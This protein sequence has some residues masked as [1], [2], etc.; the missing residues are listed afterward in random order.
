MSHDAII[1]GLSK[2]QES[3]WPEAGTAV[4]I[5]IILF[6]RHKGIVSDRWYG[7]KPMIISNSAR[8]GGVHEE[9][10]DV[11][12]EGNTVAVDGYPG[13]L[14]HFEVMSRAKSFIS[15]QYDLF[16]W[17]CEHFVAYAHGLQLKSPQ[18]AATVA[19]ATLCLGVLVATR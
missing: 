10:W 9:A 13:G 17:N 4:S 15:S 12:A 14:P 19:I 18:V 3:V 2:A 6:Y 16:R 11:F 7:G 8:S 1:E 5:S